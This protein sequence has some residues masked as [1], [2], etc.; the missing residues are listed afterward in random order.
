VDILLRVY[1]YGAGCIKKML[2]EANNNS[3][4][5]T[6]IPQTIPAGNNKISFTVLNSWFF[7]LCWTFLPEFLTT[8]VDK[9]N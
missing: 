9:E 8:H 1:F 6:F 7:P 5:G 4:K 3:Q 2:T